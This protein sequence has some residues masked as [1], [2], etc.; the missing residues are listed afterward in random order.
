MKFCSLHANFPMVKLSRW[1]L[2]YPKYPYKQGYIIN[3]LFQ[4]LTKFYQQITMSA[5]I[6]DNE[7]QSHC[8]IVY[9]T[10]GVYQIWNLKHSKDMTKHN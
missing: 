5:E 10:D 2:K 6:G 8:G 9:V 7:L 1:I 4:F 3:A